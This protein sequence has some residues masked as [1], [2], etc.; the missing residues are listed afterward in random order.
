M[1]AVRRRAVAEAVLAALALVLGLLAAVAPTWIESLLG[2]S[3]DGGNGSAEWG[4][5]LV[6][7][8]A[9]AVLALLARRD[10]ARWRAATAGGRP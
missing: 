7:W 9:A 3:P 8:A 4:L 1:R 6:F 10:G 5:V 2:F